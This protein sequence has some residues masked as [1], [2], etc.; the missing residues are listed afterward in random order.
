MSVYTAITDCVVDRLTSA[1]VSGMVGYLRPGA[2]PEGV[3]RY[4]GV[5]LGD[6][7]QPDRSTMF[8][9]T[10]W[11]TEVRLTLQARPVAG[12][13][14]TAMHAVDELFGDV[15]RALAWVA[16]PDSYCDAMRALGV[17]GYT[18]PDG[19]AVSDVYAPMAIARDV[20]VVSVPVG[21]ITCS[22]WCKHLTHPG[23]LDPHQT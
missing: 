2:A 11:I 19:D 5:Q 18:G 16:T 6:S 10:T 1:Q 7:R 12:V 21:V 14:R 22:L 9:V 3:A 17:Q 15:L 13:H 20:E 8:G 4:I 23:T